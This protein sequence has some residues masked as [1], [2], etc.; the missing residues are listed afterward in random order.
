MVDGPVLGKKIQKSADPHQS[1]RRDLGSRR[2]S[3]NR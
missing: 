2:L 3:G 1:P